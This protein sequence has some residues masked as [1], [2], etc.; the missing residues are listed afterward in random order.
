MIT[1]KV[2][3]MTRMIVKSITSTKVKSITLWENS[4]LVHSLEQLQKRSVL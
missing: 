1:T 3:V 4:T 2:I